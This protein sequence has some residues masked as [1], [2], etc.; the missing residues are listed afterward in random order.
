MALPRTCLIPF[1][2]VS[3]LGSCLRHKVSTMNAVCC[4]DDGIYSIDPY[5][6]ACLSCIKHAA[7][8][9]D[10]SHSNAA[11]EREVSNHLGVA[12]HASQRS[13]LCAVAFSHPTPINSTTAREISG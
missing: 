6:S 7:S 9:R 8:D 1:N 2:L 10:S 11:R 3:S 12:T 13:A 5:P 4:M